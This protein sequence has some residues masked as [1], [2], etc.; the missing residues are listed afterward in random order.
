MD[1]VPSRN[2]FDPTVWWFWDRG[3]LHRYR[4]MQ[5]WCFPYF[6]QVLKEIKSNFRVDVNNYYKYIGFDQV[7]TIKITNEFIQLNVTAK[8][9]RSKLYLRI[10]ILNKGCWQTATKSFL[11]SGQFWDW[12]R[13]LF[14]R[15][16][17]EEMI[18]RTCNEVLPKAFFEWFFLLKTWCILHLNAKLKKYKNFNSPFANSWPE[19]PLRSI[20]QH[21]LRSLPS[22]DI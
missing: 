2:N 21:V 13:L 7:I 12:K 11:E 6:L 22:N 3:L 10:P 1:T 9:K 4:R 16:R 5:Y 19:P 18:F 15:P 20:V 8:C 17:G 14:E